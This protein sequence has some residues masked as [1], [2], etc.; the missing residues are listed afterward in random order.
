MPIKRRVDSQSVIYTYNGIL[1]SLKW[2]DIL[3]HGTA[4]INFENMLSEISRT[5]KTN[6]V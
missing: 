6:I 3:I 5:K 2:N 1:Y 4:W